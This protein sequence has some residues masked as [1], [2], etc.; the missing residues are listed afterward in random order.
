MSTLYAP[1]K[2]LILAEANGTLL[3]TI[4]ATTVLQL[5]AQRRGLYR[6]TPYLE[7]ANAA[8][9]VTVEATWTDPVKGADSFSWYT[10]QSLAVDDYSLAPLLIRSTGGEIITLVVTAGIANNVTV[11]GW[12]EGRA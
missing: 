6:V 4:A 11:N 10:A 2:T 7:V 9:V 1:R 3:S 12:I 8:T 5:T